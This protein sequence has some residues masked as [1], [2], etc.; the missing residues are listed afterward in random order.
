MSDDGKTEATESVAAASAE[1][2]GGSAVL[3]EAQTTLLTAVL[4]ELIPASG[5]GRMPAAG[6][7]GL[8]AS[9]GTVMSA[10]PASACLLSPG[11]DAIEKEAQ[12]AGSPFPDG[13]KDSKAAVIGAV[14]A[15]HP[16][17]FEA[18]WS[19]TLVAYYQHPRVVAELGLRPGPPF[20]DG[21]EVEPSDE[22]LLAPV[23]A[24]AR[25]Y[26]EC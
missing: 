25:M 7:L 15:A 6:E 4:D 16:E 10:R 9:V 1:R 22:K 20:P 14:S 18:L 24:K 13:D 19:A 8:A 23:R 11:L 3:T 5:D 21:Y 2:D 26:R 12:A 17:F